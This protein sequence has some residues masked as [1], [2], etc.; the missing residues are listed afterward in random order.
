MRFALAYLAFLAVALC[1]GPA[2][3]QDLLR[4][5]DTRWVV[6]AS[7]R[8]L[9]K[10][11]GIAET[12]TWEFDDVRV[13]ESSNGWLAVI[14]GPISI[15]SGAKAA[16]S[17]L[18]REKNVRSDIFLSNGASFSR[19]LW[20]PMNVSIPQ[21]EYEYGDALRIHRGSLNLIITSRSQDGETHFP[22]LT[23]EQSGKVVAQGEIPE[24]A[25]S[26]G[27]ARLQEVW[28]D[29]KSAYPQLVFSSYWLGA[30]CCTVVKFYTYTDD[31]WIELSAGALDG[32]VGFLFRDMDGDGN[33]EILGKDNSFLYA[34]A[35]Y[36]FSWSPTRILRLEGTEV[37]D[38]RSD[39]RYTYLYRRDLYRLEHIAERNPELWSSNGFL[40][41]WVATKA[42]V[43]EFDEAWARML[44]NYD[45]SDTWPLTKCLVD[46]TEGSCPRES[47]VAI[48]FPAAL[49]EHLVKNG[50]IGT[51][52]YRERWQYRDASPS[53]I[54]L[55]RVPAPVE[56]SGKDRR[57]PDKPESETR[58]GTRV[59]CNRCRRSRHQPSCGGRL[60]AGNNPE[61]REMGAYRL[62]GFARHDQR[63][64]S[65]QDGW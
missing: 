6:L 45:R 29:R 20:R 19:T 62:G 61:A 54:T 21:W 33:F 28:L 26:N 22:V 4:T 65:S 50:Y 51:T 32:D 25:T 24:S 46:L 11:I 42:I 58:S 53:K 37:R 48:S 63:S 12:Y 31:G 14:A 18:L 38:L 7:A 35:P 2:A 56:D 15:Q 59:L 60:L 10:A 3:G 36:A 8:E 30:H 47:K 64:S 34:F 44:A 27:N 52:E 23:I 55:N 5:G 16:K 13:V 40:A 41:A 39:P 1:C 17:R 43:G 49:H 9:D 57:R